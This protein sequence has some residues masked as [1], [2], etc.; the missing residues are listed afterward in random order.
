MLLRGVPLILSFPKEPIIKFSKDPALEFVK[1]CGCGEFLL[2]ERDDVLSI[3]VAVMVCAW[4]SVSSME[5]I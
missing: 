3:V 2:I 4:T 1:G 5:P